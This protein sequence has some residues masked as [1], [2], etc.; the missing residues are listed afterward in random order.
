MA[1]RLEEQQVD[2]DVNSFLRRELLAANDRDV[3]LVSRHLD[4]I[5]NAL[6]DR[7]EEFDRLFFGGSI[8]KHTYVEGLS[9]VDSLVVLNDPQ[10]G[11][12]SPDEFR[13]E[14]ARTLRAQLSAGQVEDVRTGLRSV[15]VVYRDGT[16]IQLLP[17]VSRGNT[18][19]ISSS[20]GGSWQ[21]G[22]RPTAFTDRLTT[23]NRAQGGTVVPVIKLA[24]QVIATAIPEARRPSGYHVETL[25]VEVFTS[26]DGPRTPKAMVA[27]F[28]RAAANRINTPMPDVTGQSRYVDE[29]L[30]GSGS[31][32]RGQ[33]ARE[34]ARIAG[35]ME[36]SRSVDD[37]RRLF[38]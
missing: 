17:A 37:W 10:L 13:R 22:I 20:D 27:H 12:R 33:V 35:T 38:G 24:K 15:T 4:E 8:A 14:F 29:N 31:G 21:H 7:V 18:I 11:E 23:A 30:G 19:S 3:S 1:E 16:E 5:E 36:H 34:F 2:A 26:Y 28:F 6:H 32:E 9:D 25:A